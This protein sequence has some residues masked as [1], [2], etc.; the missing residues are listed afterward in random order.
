MAG[1]RRLTTFTVLIFFLSLFPAPF[2]QNFANEPHYN[3]NFQKR[4]KIWVKGAK[5]GKRSLVSSWIFFITFL[6]WGSF[7][8]RFFHQVP[9]R[10]LNIHQVP[11]RFPIF[12]AYPW[13]LEK[14]PKITFLGF[15]PNHSYQ[16]KLTL[17]NPN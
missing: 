17:T 10:F 12:I 15:R 13:G 16:P 5:G 6:L 9:L 2:H 14:I 3:T 7:F 1:F 4:K 11:S 8:F